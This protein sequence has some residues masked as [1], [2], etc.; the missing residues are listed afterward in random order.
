MA[1]RKSHEMAP[2]TRPE[3]VEE[4]RMVTPESG[5]PQTMNQIQLVHWMTGMRSAPIV[6]QKSKCEEIEKPKPVEVENNTATRK[7]MFSNQRPNSGGTEI[8]LAKVVKGNRSQQQGMQLEYYPPIIKEG[9]KVGRLNQIEVTEQTQK[10]QASLIGFESEDDKKL[11]IQ[12]GP[13]TFNNRPMILKQWESKFQM[14]KEKT[15]NISIWE[16]PNVMLI[17]EAKGTYMEQELEYEWRPAFCEVCFQIGK[18]EVNCEKA[19]I[20]KQK[21]RGE[22]HD[23]QAGIK[24]QK[25]M[26]WKVKA[27]MELEGTTEV[28]E[29]AISQDKEMKD[30]GQE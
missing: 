29:I 10:W 19:P 2:A 27:I 26:Q 8:N 13:Y 6:M 14:S 28:Q 9:V 7:L 3:M 23:R 24:Q 20:E 21:Y 30:Q 5:I 15:I 11:V 1:R 4:E 17:E 12:K 16:L 25:K 18:H 22:K